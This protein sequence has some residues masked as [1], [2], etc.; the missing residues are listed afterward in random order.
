MAIFPYVMTENILEGAGG[1][2][3]EYCNFH[4]RYVLKMS[5]NYVGR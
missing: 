5:L 4:L 1:R 2:G 3:V